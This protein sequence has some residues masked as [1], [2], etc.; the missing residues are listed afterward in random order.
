MTR[1]QQLPSGVVHI[2]TPYTERRFFVSG[3]RVYEQNPDPE[4]DEDIIAFEGLGSYGRQLRATDSSL[5][6]VIRMAWKEIN[7]ARRYTRKKEDNHE[8][9]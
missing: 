3:T 9:A 2:S 1:I 6:G 4:A 8:P 7:L 5:L